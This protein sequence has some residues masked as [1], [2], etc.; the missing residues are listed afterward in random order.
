VS[1]DMTSHHLGGDLWEV[2]AMY[3]G[4]P[5]VV[6]GDVVVRD[7]GNLRVWSVV[8]TLGDGEPGGEIRD[9]GITGIHGSYVGPELDFCELLTDI[10]G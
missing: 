8:D 10:I 6:E 2:T 9:F 3:S 4:Q 5:F 1:R 7:R